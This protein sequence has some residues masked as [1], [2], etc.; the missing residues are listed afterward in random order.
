MKNRTDELWTELD[1]FIEE[2]SVADVL[3]TISF[4]FTGGVTFSLDSLQGDIIT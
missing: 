2:R 4:H 3:L 1:A